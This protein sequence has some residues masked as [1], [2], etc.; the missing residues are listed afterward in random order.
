MGPHRE[1][2]I[3][4]WWSARGEG[5]MQNTIIDKK[6]IDEE[7]MDEI[8]RKSKTG[9]IPPPKNG[10]CPQCG[11]KLKTRYF[12]QV[13]RIIW[14]FAILFQFFECTTCGYQYAKRLYP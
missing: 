12:K 9:E 2:A 1:L 14:R 4:F 7:R 8:L 11:N 13:W 3:K 5:N 6:E 10:Y